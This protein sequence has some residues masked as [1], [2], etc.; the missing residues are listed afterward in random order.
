MWFL[1]LVVLDP[2][3]GKS[4]QDDQSVSFTVFKKPLWFQQL[5]EEK[6]V[7]A[8]RDHAQSM[9]YLYLYNIY[10]YIYY[11]YINGYSSFGSYSRTSHQP[12]IMFQVDA[13][14]FRLKAAWRLGSSRWL[15][16]CSH[17]RLVLAANKIRLLLI[18]KVIHMPYAKSYYIIMRLKKL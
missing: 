6:G 9:K 1:N 17:T 3:L 12:K 10:I 14:C 8:H 5:V 15:P 13:P 7:Q 2:V 16:S 11:I 18:Q 4:L